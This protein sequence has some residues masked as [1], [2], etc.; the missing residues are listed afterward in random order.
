MRDLL[1]LRVRAGEQEI[2]RKRIW[3][4]APQKWRHPLKRADTTID[5]FIGQKVIALKRER[6]VTFSAKAFNCSQGASPNS[7]WPMWNGFTSQEHGQQ[8][9][10]PHW[11]WTWQNT[12]VVCSPR[13]RFFSLFLP[14]QCFGVQGLTHASQG[15]YHWATLTSQISPHS[16]F[17]S[18]FSWL[19]HP[20]FKISP[21]SSALNYSS[22]VFASGISHRRLSVKS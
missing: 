18:E 3:T 6:R 15:H 9:C 16:T 14:L 2:I 22:L 17:C 4:P 8:A 13:W 21:A 20:R 19:H 10:E 11:G 5:S 7:P 12:L 1:C